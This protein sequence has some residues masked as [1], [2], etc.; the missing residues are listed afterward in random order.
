M[1]TVQARLFLLLGLRAQPTQIFLIWNKNKIGTSKVFYT[2]DFL[3]HRKLPCYTR[4]DW[5]FPKKSNCMHMFCRQNG[6]VS[7][8]CLKIVFFV[9]KI[10]IPLWKYSNI[11]IL[12]YYFFFFSSSVSKL[13]TL[14]DFH[15][16]KYQDDNFIFIF[17]SSYLNFF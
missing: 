15:G 6:K 8:F 14:S 9:L 12:E 2:V 11:N 5:Q 17:I 4:I 7:I 10:I 3:R 16:K 1:T 13:F